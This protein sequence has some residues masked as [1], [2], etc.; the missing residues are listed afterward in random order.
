MLESPETRCVL[1]AQGKGAVAGMCTAQLV[2][3]TA[4][5]APSAL[6]EDVVV[7][8]EFRGQGVGRKLMD[9]IGAWAV[10]AGATRLQLLADKNNAAAFGF[11]EK[12]GWRRTQLVCLRNTNFTA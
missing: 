6:V 12:L 5:G 4:E 1:V 7:A 9:A 8:R 2:I 3:S 11:Y 10:T